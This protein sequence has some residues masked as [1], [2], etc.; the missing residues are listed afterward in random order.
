MAHQAVL[1]NE[2]DICSVRVKCLVAGGLLFQTS[3]RN[4]EYSVLTFVSKIT[5]SYYDHH[6]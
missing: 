3:D 6:E 5:S 2:K 4:N 1:G